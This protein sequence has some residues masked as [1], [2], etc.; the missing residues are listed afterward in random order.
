M[1]PLLDPRGHLEQQLLRARMQRPVCLCTNSASGTPQVRWREMHQSGRLAIM[2]VMRCSP[3]AGVQ[4]TCV[5]SSQRMRAQPRLVHADE[6]LRR[7]AKDQRRLVA[8]A[9]RVAVPQRL[10]S[11]QRAAA[12]EFLHDHCVGLIDPQPGHQRRARP[13]SGHPAPRD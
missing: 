11:Q 10:L 13:R 3:Q 5:M 9:M 1:P 6:P 2:V 8:P 7:G 4:C 12:L